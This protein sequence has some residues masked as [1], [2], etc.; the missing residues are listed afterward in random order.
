M[1]ACILI[2][3]SRDIAFDGSQAVRRGD[4]V[5]RPRGGWTDARLIDSNETLEW[6]YAV[7]HATCR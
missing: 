5:E 2:R 1:A 7:P 4:L 6:R 3:N